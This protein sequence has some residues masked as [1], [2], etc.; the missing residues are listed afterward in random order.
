MVEKLSSQSSHLPR[1]PDKTIQKLQN[2]FILFILIHFISYFHFSEVHF[3]VKHP[4]LACLGMHG[5]MWSALGRQLVQL[6][7]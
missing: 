5:A 2:R 7:K 4:R 6:L 1:F 3:H